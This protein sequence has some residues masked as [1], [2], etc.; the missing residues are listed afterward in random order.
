MSKELVL[1]TG[2]NGFIAGH[3]AEELL[4]QGYRVRGTARGA[5]YDLLVETVKV[6]GLEFVQVD[7]IATGSFTEALKGVDAVIHIAC[8]LPGRKDIDETFKSAIDGALNVVRQAQKA[9]VKKIVVTSSFG[10]LLSP[11]HIPAFHGLNLN[12]TNWGVADD[13]EY[14]K[15]KEDKYYVY[16]TAKIKAEKAVWDFA[17]QH[18]ELNVATVLPGYVVGP[19]PKTFPLPTSVATMGTNDFIHTVINKGDPPFAPNWIVDGRDVG[20]GHVRVLQQLP[21]PET[22][23]KRFIINGATYTWGQVAT[24]L[25]KAKPEIADRIIALEDIKPLPGVLTTLDT[26]RAKEILGFTEF[27]PTEQTIEEGADDILEL[28]KQWAKK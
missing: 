17:A 15:N 13:E 4:K 1:V 25:K 26:T 21:L 10:C 12:E 20:K 28:E 22:D 2:I 14:E 6:P 8:P 18:P 27:I 24:H 19:Y 9:G 16:F 23:V 3:T 5:K 7:D 11:T